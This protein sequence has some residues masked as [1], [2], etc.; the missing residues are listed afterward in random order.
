V[1]LDGVRG[2]LFDAGGTLI[3]IDGERLCRAA[4]VDVDE[5]VFS[6]AEVGATKAMRAFMKANPGNTDRERVPVFLDGILTGLGLAEPERRRKAAAAVEAEHMRSNLWSRPAAGAAETLAGLRERGLRTGVVS[7]ADGRVRRLLEEA[8]L[9][10]FLEVVIDSFEVGFEKP[11]P[12]IFFAAAERIS[13][14]PHAC[15]FVGDIYEIDVVGARAAGLEPI[16]IGSG[17]APPT[18]PVLRI[19]RLAELLVL[20]P[21][22]KA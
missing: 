13:T 3:H 10:P 18:D 9:S 14:P 2:I 12:R 21:D 5:T 6:R 11:D 22:W 8:G 15:A 4:G 19:A 16:L 7:N 17:E 20:L 1:R